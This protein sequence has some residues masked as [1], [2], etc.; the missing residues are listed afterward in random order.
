MKVTSYVDATQRAYA[1]GLRRGEKRLI[2]EHTSDAG[3][4]T[5]A[6]YRCASSGAASLLAA[7]NRRPD[8]LADKPERA[9]R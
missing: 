4:G 7:W 5:D 8:K 1:Y 9:G 3:I 2:E 6:A